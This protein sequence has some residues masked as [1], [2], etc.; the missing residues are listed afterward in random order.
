MN[1]ITIN[2]KIYIKKEINKERYVL[3]RTYS[4][5]IFAGYLE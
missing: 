5:G 2:G 4:A 3:V 1:E